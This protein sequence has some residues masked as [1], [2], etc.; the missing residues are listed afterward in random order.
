M[1]A[2]TLQRWRNVGFTRWAASI[3]AVALLLAVS[4][5]LAHQHDTEHTVSS[6]EQTCELCLQLTTVGAAPA[7]ASAPDGLPPARRLLPDNVSAAP[8]LQLAHSY[9]SRAPPRS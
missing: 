2:P 1:R 7:L 8:T 9:L 5:W 6:I 4:A 3:A